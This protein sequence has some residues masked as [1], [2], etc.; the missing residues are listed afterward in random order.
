VA[1]WSASPS[2]RAH[3]ALFA[4]YAALIGFTVYKLVNGHSGAVLTLPAELSSLIVLILS[5]R[6][7]RQREEHSP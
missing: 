1:R 3:V 6:K 5:Y 4:V 7:T 2:P